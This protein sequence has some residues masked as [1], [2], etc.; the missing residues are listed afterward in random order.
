MSDADCPARRGRCAAEWRCP[1]IP[2]GEEGGDGEDDE[3]DDDEDD[4]DEDNHS[5]DNH[6]EDN[7]NKDTH[8]EDTHSEDTHNK[9]THN[10]DIVTALDTDSPLSLT[11]APT[12]TSSALAAA[13]GTGASGSA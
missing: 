6:D 1:G 8:S 13:R 3:D 7:H 11:C 9:D 5:E 2:G 4:D 10:K 12:T